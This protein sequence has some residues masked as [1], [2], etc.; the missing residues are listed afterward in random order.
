MAQ[1]LDRNLGLGLVWT[2]VAGSGLWFMTPLGEAGWP[3]A[4]GLLLMAAGW[5]II[6]RLP[7][8]TTAAPP[9]CNNLI[10]DP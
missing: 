8:G 1:L 7:T 10:R 5:A 2:A 9:P 3:A 4:A 6:D